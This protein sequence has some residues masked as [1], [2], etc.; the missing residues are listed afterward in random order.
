[1]K[2][3]FVCVLFFSLYAQAWNRVGNGAHMIACYSSGGS[4]LKSVELFDFYERNEN[5]EFTRVKPGK[6]DFLGIL[7]GVFSTLEKVNPKQAEQYRSRLLGIQNEIEFK[8]GV[9]LTN[10][11]D[12]M[13]V[14]VPSDKNC[15]MEQAVVRKNDAL[16]GEKRFIVRKEFWDKLSEEG[17]AGV[18]LHEIVYEHFFMLG[19]K[20]SVKA[21]NYNSYLMSEKFAKATPKEYW[22]YIK[23]LQI[24][25][26][27]E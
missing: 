16:P 5:K 3:L 22:E 23:A 11:N 14:F 8:K 27:Q 9:R 25:I 10:T 17:R 26:Y 15:H 2:K 1:M 18:L 7:A 19:E 13:E 21:R 6:K 12:A 4:H 20:D 24:P